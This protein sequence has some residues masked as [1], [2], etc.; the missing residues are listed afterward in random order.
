MEKPR[1]FTSA[2]KYKKIKKINMY[3][4]SRQNASIGIVHEA[5]FYCILCCRK[6]KKKEQKKRRK[7]FVNK[8]KMKK[9]KEK[10]AHKFQTLFSL[11]ACTQIIEAEMQ[12]VYISST[13][14]ICA[15]FVAVPSLAFLPLLTPSL[16][17]LA[18]AIIC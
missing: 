16:F 12:F 8:M 11:I 3:L 14:K 1:A 6:K 7:I 5:L 10:L 18:T 2:G 4:K 15:F 13:V 9:K 17:S